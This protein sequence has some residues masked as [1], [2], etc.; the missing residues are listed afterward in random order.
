MPGTEPGPVF[1][2]F[3]AFS[4]ILVEEEVKGMLSSTMLKQPCGK[5]FFELLR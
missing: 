3:S 1:L 5:G 4:I 2:L